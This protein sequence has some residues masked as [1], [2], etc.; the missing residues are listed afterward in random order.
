MNNRAPIEFFEK[1]IAIL[2]IHVQNLTL[3]ETVRVMEI[4]HQRKIGSDRL[5]N[6]YLYFYIEKKVE[7][8]TVTL[9]VKTL[10][11]LGDR[12]YVEDPIFWMDYMF[13]WVYQRS[14]TKDAA[15]K[16][17][18][19]L[20]ALRIKCPSIPNINTIIDYIDTLIA[21]FDSVSGYEDMAPEAKK[22]I[23]MRG[24]LPQNV[25]IQLTKVGKNSMKEASVSLAEANRAVKSE[26]QKAKRMQILNNPELIQKREARKE[27]MT[28]RIARRGGE[29]MI[30]TDDEVEGEDSDA[31]EETK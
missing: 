3:Y 11:I 21:K 17:W 8:F 15:M 12:E 14:F 27:K 26:Q 13:P 4:C 23:R 9:F 25:K 20:V 2:P 29:D 1:I 28:K 7:K 30:M 31:K 10:K 16:I 5:F 6:E 24:D 19:E 18:E 22:E